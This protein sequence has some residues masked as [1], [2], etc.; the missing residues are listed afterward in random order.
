MTHENKLGMFIHWGIYSMTGIQDQ[1]FA[2][3]DMKREDYEALMHSF[4][5]VNYDPYP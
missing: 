2:R 4:N 5:P 3:M 1:A